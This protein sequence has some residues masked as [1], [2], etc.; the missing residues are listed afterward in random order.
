M[1]PD[2]KTQPAKEVRMSA[3]DK[4]RQDLVLKM[5]KEL[6]DRLS[7]LRY[8]EYDGVKSIE[9][10]DAEIEVLQKQLHCA[11]SYLVSFLE[12]SNLYRAD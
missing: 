9:Q 2:N 12:Q 5:I 3:A 10:R 4:V 8:C 6:K 1:K 7:V 11:H